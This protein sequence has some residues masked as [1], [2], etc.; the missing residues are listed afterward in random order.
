MSTRISRDQ[1][2]AAGG[3]VQLRVESVLKSLYA[4]PELPA[5]YPPD[6]HP[7]TFSI[8]H[9]RPDFRRTSS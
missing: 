8:K 4:G 5:E 2:A 3:D 6:A 1:R 7:R 9:T